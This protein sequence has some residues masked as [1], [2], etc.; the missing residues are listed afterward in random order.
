[1]S[2]EREHVYAK[3]PDVDV[4]LAE[5]LARVCVNEYTSLGE[6]EI[7]LARSHGLDNLSNRLHCADLSRRM[8]GEDMGRKATVPW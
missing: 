8:H 1:M 7:G 6:A 5:C 2:R 4:D 3:S